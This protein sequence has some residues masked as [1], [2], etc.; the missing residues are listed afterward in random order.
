MTIRGQTGTMS[1]FRIRPRQAAA[2]TAIPVTGQ[3]REETGVS[4]IKFPGLDSMFYLIYVSSAVQLMDDEALLS[5]LQQS[6]KKNARLE[7]TGMLLYKQ[8]NFMQLLEGEKEVVLEL[9]DT[10]KKDSRHKDLITIITDDIADRNFEDWSMGFQNMDKTGA[11]PNYN[12]YIEENLNFEA[13]Q[14]DALKAY[15]FMVFFNEANR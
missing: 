13:F 11:L 1:L 15:R 4:T 5:L 2:T 8:G 14:A 12:D 3:R 7:V 9:F 10:I 6:R